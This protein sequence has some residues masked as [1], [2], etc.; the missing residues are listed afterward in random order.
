M[1]AQTINEKVGKAK[2]EDKCGQ[3]ITLFI[4][5]RKY[6]NVLDVIVHRGNHTF[7]PWVAREGGEKRGCWEVEVC[8]KKINLH[9]GRYVELQFLFLSVCINTITHLLSDNCFLLL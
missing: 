4:C 9:G 6:C 8:A 7:F 2:R 1:E 5:Y 3:F